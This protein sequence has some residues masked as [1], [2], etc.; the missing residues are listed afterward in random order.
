MKRFLGTALILCL[1]LSCSDK[2][3]A[4]WQVERGASAGGVLARASTGNV[5]RPE[6][7]EGGISVRKDL[8]VGAY[9]EWELGPEIAGMAD[10]NLEWVQGSERSILVAEALSSAGGPNAW[11]RFRA[12]LDGFSGAAQLEYTRAEE[13]LL[14]SQPRV[15]LPSATGRRISVVWIVI[16]TL[17]ADYLGCYGHDRPTSPEID[18]FARR[19]LVFERAVSPASWTLP[20][21]TSMFTGLYAESHGV[22][23]AEHRMQKSALSFVEVFASAGYSTGAIVSGTFTDSFWGFDQGFDEYDDLGMVVDDHEGGSVEISAM[24][25]RAHRRITSPE[26]TDR[27]LDWLD[28]NGDRQFFLLAHYFDPH[29]DFVEHAGFSEQFAPRPSESASFGKLDPNPQATAKLRAL[30]EGEIAFT[31]HHIGR[32]LERLQTESF[33]DDVAIVIT[34]DHG[35]EFYERR[36][37][38]HGNSLFN[39][40]VRVPF[41]LYVPGVEARRVTESMTTLDLAPTLLELSGLADSFGQGLSLVSS[42]PA[43]AAPLKRQVYTSLYPTLATT[44]GETSSQSAYRVDEG[45]DA[46]IKDKNITIPLLF[47]WSDDPLQERNLG[48]QRSK[49]VKRLLEGYERVKPELLKQQGQPE[50]I[51]L[52]ADQLETLRG[53]GYVGDG[54]E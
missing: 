9:V 7:R 17:R 2:K 51:E 3:Q 47:S 25:E 50:L 27:A 41:I 5:S 35:E 4:S 21:M 36:W 40:L 12:P 8:P 33:R 39:E 16:D 22:L 29:Q 20:A 11:R 53:L 52:S 43:D 34:A 28:R 48:G 30:Y 18:K 10:P 15:I 44:P 19:S 49:R 23:H 32:L 46:A 13:N 14:R 1:F 37:L 24:K 38:G 26:V 54:K 45:G 42:F 31:D 6:L